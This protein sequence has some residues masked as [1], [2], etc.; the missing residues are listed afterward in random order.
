MNN[1]E[2]G[3]KFRKRFANG[4]RRLVRRGKLRLEDEWSKLQDSAKLEA[5][6]EEIT[7]TD[8]NVFIEGPPH[9]K[10]KPTH[11]LKYLARYMTGGPISNRR[12]ISDDE[13][14]VTFWARSKD[15]AKSNK[16]KPFPLS[17]TEFVRRWAMHI[18]PKGYTRS[19]SYGG[20]HG[21]KRQ[22][23]LERC[24]ELLE[25]TTDDDPT[26]SGEPTES[27]E[28]SLPT[29]VHCE[30]PMVCIEQQS[31]PSWRRIFERDIYADP[32]IYSPMHHIHVRTP[33]AHP[34][35]DYG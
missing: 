5:W 7:T 9:G 8:W 12:L 31:R 32:A 33:T 24:R 26:S 15:K 19:R 2:L 30:I 20:Y 11:V 28:P 18:L 22:D 23:Y 29:C 1:V 6:L 4:L 10:S 34:I 27:P 14:M 13:G 16:S 35:D 25:I 17:G 21:S 3:R